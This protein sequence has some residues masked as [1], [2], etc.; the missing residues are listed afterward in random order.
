M[1]ILIKK[2]NG[3]G[4]EYNESGNLKFEGEYFNGER[5]GQGKEYNNYGNLSFE[6]EYSNGKKKME[7]EKNIMVMVI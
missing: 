5:N 3:N 1:K 6:G 2:R 4:K 7:K